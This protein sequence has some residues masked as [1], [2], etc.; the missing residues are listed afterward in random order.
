[1]R[2]KFTVVTDSPL[3]I[4][5]DPRLLD[6]MLL[7]LVPL[8]LIVKRRSQW[9]TKGVTLS[10]CGQQI[11]SSFTGRDP[12]HNGF[13]CESTLS[14]KFPIPDFAQPFLRSPQAYVGVNT[15]LSIQGLALE[16]LIFSAPIS[17]FSVI[18]HG[19]NAM[20]RV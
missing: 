10:L 8:I 3:S 4:S 2:C 5:I 14:W 16:I 15:E 20:L 13:S 12:N 11:C 7:E 18:L 19:A 1:M 6:L 17:D 9:Q